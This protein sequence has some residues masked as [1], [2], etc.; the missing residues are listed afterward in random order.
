MKV[1]TGHTSCGCHNF[2]THT[3]RA[4][5]RERGRVRGMSHCLPST[6]ARISVCHISPSSL[7]FC[8]ALFSLLGAQICGVSTKVFKSSSSSSSSF[9]RRAFSVKIFNNLRHIRAIWYGPNI[10]NACLI[11]K[12]IEMKREREREGKLCQVSLKHFE[13]L[14]KKFNVYYK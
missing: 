11:Y 9:K 4:C 8:F 3:E 13:E 6:W 14:F 7:W 5:E 2:W 10:N 12:Y 1:I